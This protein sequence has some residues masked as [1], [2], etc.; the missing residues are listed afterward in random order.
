M[1]HD[2]PLQLLLDNAPESI[3]KAPRDWAQGKGVARWHIWPDKPIQKAY[4]ERFDK[5]CRN[6]VRDCHVFKLPQGASDMTAHQLRRYN[7]QR[8][9]TALGRIPPVAYRGKLCP[10]LD[11]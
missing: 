10:T 6:E 3:A 5:T 8:P 2:A 7:H 1:L 4:V 11:F 9:Q